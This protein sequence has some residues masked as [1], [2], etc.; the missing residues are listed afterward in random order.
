LPQPSGSSTAFSILCLQRRMESRRRA[1]K[2]MIYKEKRTEVLTREHH[3]FCCAFVRTEATQRPDIAKPSLFFSRWK[4]SRN[5]R[6]KT[7]AQL[8]LVYAES[9][10]KRR[11]AGENDVFWY[12]GE[13]MGKERGESTGR[14]YNNSRFQSTH[15][16]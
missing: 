10:R 12:L 16:P 8:F 13:E 5:Q 6:H 9:L 1:A 2:P 3:H 4:K 11:H 14:F 7:R 15:T